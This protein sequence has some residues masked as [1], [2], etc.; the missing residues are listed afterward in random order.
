MTHPSHNSLRSELGEELAALD[1]LDDKQ[2]ARL[3]KLIQDARQRQHEQIRDAM[4]GALK[5]VPA[6]LRG[7]IKKLFGRS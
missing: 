6:V 7:P 3:L 1:R 5:F 4:D 2:Q